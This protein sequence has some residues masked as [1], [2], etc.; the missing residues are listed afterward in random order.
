MLRRARVQGHAH[1]QFLDAFPCFRMQ[2]TLGQQGAGKSFQ[3]GI[4]GHAK[5]ITDG[6][7][8]ITT[9]RF[10]NLAQH[11]VVRGKGHAHGIRMLFPFLGTAFDIGEQK[12]DGAGRQRRHDE[13]E[14]VRA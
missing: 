14:C 10:E 2:S 13:G 5:G 9:L 1:L 11:L 4:K 6:L 12:R 7:E 8:N 3:S